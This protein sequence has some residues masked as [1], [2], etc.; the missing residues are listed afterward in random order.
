M[1]DKPS[2][3]PEMVHTAFLITDSKQNLKIRRG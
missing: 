1:F 2:K 3:V